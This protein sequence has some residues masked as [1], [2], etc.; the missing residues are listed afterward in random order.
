MSANAEIAASICHAEA[1]VL[2][3][4]QVV[5]FGANAVVQHDEVFHLPIDV[6]QL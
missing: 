1:A 3:E 5:E 2:V 6:F 4:R